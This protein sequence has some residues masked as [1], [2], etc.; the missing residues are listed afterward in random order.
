MSTSLM[1][2]VSTVRAES[3]V[4][5]TVE[6]RSTCPGVDEWSKVLSSRP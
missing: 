2:N 5:A 4:K 6:A 1:T 3:G